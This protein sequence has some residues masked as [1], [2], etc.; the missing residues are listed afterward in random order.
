MAQIKTNSPQERI[1]FLVANLLNR[2]LNW[3]TGVNCETKCPPGLYGEDCEHECRCY[4]NSSCD[5]QDGSCI[6]NKGWRG[7]DCSEP[8]PEGYYGLGG[9]RFHFDFQY[10]IKSLKI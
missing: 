8:C 10:D 3:I 7:T 9:N 6:C 4:N 5:A 1:I 2:I